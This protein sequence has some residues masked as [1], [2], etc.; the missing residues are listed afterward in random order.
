MPSPT[1]IRDLLRRYYDAVQKER[2][3]RVAVLVTPGV[4]PKMVSARRE[5]QVSLAAVELEI[6]DIFNPLNDTCCCI[7]CLGD[8]GD[9]PLCPNCLDRDAEEA[10]AEDDHEARM[11]VFRGDA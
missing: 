3:A 4:T 2:V 9:Q 8:S 5:A 1:Q 7:S 10:Q 11:E 6:E